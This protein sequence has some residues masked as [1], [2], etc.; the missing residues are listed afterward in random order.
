MLRGGGRRGHTHRFER[1]APRVLGACPGPPRLTI[2]CRALQK[3]LSYFPRIEK[4]KLTQ[5][6]DLSSRILFVIYKKDEWS[7]IR[8]DEAGKNKRSSQTM[9]HI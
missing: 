8:V 7:P 2:V 4:K 1:P 6:K 5:S 3:M 9:Y